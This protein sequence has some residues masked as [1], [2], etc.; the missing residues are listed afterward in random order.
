MAD[1]VIKSTKQSIQNSYEEAPNR[2][3]C[4]PDEWWEYSERTERNE[5]RAKDEISELVGSPLYFKDYICA[6]WRPNQLTAP[7]VVSRFYPH[8]KLIIDE[9]AKDA[10]DLLLR[11]ITFDKLGIKY[12]GI[13]PGET[14]SK[15][16]FLNRLKEVRQKWSEN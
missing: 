1:H 15:S 14:L 13:A 8:E 12:L 2:Q 7:F 10:A 5:P 4:T 9:R 16:V 11:R 6:E 3:T